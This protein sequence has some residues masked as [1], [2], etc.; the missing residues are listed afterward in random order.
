MIQRRGGNVVNRLHASV[1]PFQLACSQRRRDTRVPGTLPS[2][3]P[4]HLPCDDAYH[5]RR[6]HEE[7]DRLQGGVAFLRARLPRD[8]HQ[9]RRLALAAG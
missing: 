3:R 5:R 6:C 7:I 2:G 1:V 9:R 4:Q 8:P